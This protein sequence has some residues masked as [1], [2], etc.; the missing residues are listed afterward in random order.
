ME[1]MHYYWTNLE[2]P[3]VF[4]VVVVVVT[5][6]PFT[7]FSHHHRT[8]STAHHISSPLNTSSK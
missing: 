8:I 2:A 6:F 5:S 1:L 4:G 3:G 7:Q